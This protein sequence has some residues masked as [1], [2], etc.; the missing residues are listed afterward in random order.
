[1]D[2]GRKSYAEALVTERT[3]RP[4]PELLRELYVERRHTQQ[5]IADA[6]GVS[7]MAINA[8]LQKYRITR[9]DR[10]PVEIPA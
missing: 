7:R 1:M 2:D 5:E 4:V 9:E 8:W 10:G 3:G 6:L